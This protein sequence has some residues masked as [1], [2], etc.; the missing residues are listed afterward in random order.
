MLYP[1]NV[2]SLAMPL[3]I[4]NMFSLYND[5]EFEEF[6][7]WCFRL[8]TIYYIKLKIRLSVC[9]FP[10]YTIYWMNGVL[11][12][13]QPQWVCSRLFWLAGLALGTFRPKF[14]WLPVAKLCI[15]AWL[16]YNILHDNLLLLCAYCCCFLCYR[17]TI[18]LCL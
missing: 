12:A 9:I 17:T 7:I 3:F 1:A 6:R 4:G 10:H 18:K 13:R 8:D 5:S 2:L 15:H 14:K 11:W 16:Q